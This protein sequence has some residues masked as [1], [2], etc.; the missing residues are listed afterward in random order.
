MHEAVNPKPGDYMPRRYAKFGVSNNPASKIAYVGVEEYYICG[1]NIELITN[2]LSACSALSII[3]CGKVFLAHIPRNHAD[4]VPKMRDEIIKKLGAEDFN[5]IPDV[6]LKI[7]LGST[8]DQTNSLQT[9]LELLFELKLLDRVIKQLQDYIKNNLSVLSKLTQIY[10]ANLQEF[11]AIKSIKRKSGI[12]EVNDFIE[13]VKKYFIDNKDCVLSKG[14][15]L[16]YAEATTSENINDFIST[17]NAVALPIHNPTLNQQSLMSNFFGFFNS[18]DHISINEAIP[19]PELN[20]VESIIN[21]FELTILAYLKHQL[22]GQHA[23]LFAEEPAH[24]AAAKKLY[25]DLQLFRIATT[26]DTQK[27]ESIIQKLESFINIEQKGG[28]ILAA[29]LQEVSQKIIIVSSSAKYE[30]K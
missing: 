4:Y 5:A 15:E 19:K 14:K 30:L 29:A 8:I 11:L 3:A 6:K 24:A 23:K 28:K 2:G 26:P 10:D 25:D 22:P 17:D 12:K 18:I 27:L 16:S 21:S 9:I 1:S 20:N 13:R 7:D